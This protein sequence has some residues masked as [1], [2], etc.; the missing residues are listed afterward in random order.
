MNKNVFA[1]L[2]CLMFSNAHPK[3]SDIL[4]ESPRDFL[5]RTETE[6]DNVSRKRFKLYAV[7]DVEKFVNEHDSVGE[8]RA[9]IF[10][11]R[12]IGLN[13]EEKLKALAPIIAVPTLLSSGL[14]HTALRDY[15]KTR[16]LISGT[17]GSLGGAII[18][19]L[20]SGRAHYDRKRALI[21]K[22]LN[23]SECL[24]EIASN[25]DGED[26]IFNNEHAH[27][28]AAQKAKNEGIL[29]FNHQ[30]QNS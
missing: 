19:F 5:V 8:F 20:W 13:L 3:L 25:G 29:C 21:A 27:K 24:H 26:G 23:C 6:A 1:V 9:Q 2:M 15:R 11:E 10:N 16:W 28:Y 22:T 7:P 4:R 14:N 17:L 18:G 30:K 12:V